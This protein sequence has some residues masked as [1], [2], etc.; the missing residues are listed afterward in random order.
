MSTSRHRGNGI[1]ASNRTNDGFDL[2]EIPGLLE[3]NMLRNDV[4]DPYKR[5]VRILTFDN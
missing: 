5:I 2:L 3:I 1:I 4:P